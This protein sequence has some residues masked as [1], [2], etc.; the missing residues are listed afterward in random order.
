MERIVVGADGEPSYAVEIA[1]GI[2]PL[3]G[4]EESLAAVASGVADVGSVIAQ[5]SRDILQTLKEG[6]E[7]LVPS[8]VE[9]EFGVSLRGDAGIPI[10][11]KASGEATF[12]VRVSWR[13]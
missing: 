12:K 8:D 5:A 6:L 7:D 3:R 2:S 4:A 13:P 1:P 10:I 9:L 11:A